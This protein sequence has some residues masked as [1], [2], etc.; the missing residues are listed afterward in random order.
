M[1]AK[2]RDLMDYLICNCQLPQMYKFVNYMQQEVQHMQQKSVNLFEILLH[3]LPL[4][5]VDLQAR[6]L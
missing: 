3:L 2:R 4:E 1:M 6:V 5:A